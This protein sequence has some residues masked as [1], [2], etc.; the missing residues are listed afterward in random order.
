MSESDAPPPDPSDPPANQAATEAP[1]QGE[2]VHAAMFQGP[3]P[4]AAE[5][6]RYDEVTP[7][8]GERILS[9]A[10]A[11]QRHRHELE[12]RKLKAAD[13]DQKASR[14]QV[15]RGQ[16]FG[17]IVSVSAIIGGTVIAT[18]SSVYGS[19]AGAIMGGIVGSGGLASVIVAFTTH[20]G[21]ADSKSE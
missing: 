6:A 13:E 9:M 7:G 11:E 18:I 15:K 20:H 3:L 19:T 5:F 12:E 10:E 17:L 14:V 1:E 8:A 4:P 16:W 2:V 21:E